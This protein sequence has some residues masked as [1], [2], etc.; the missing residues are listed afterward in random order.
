MWELVERERERSVD[1]DE[2]GTAGRKAPGA[3]RARMPRPERPAGERMDKCA[4]K[5]EAMGTR[6]VDG[7]SGGLC[8]TLSH[9]SDVGVNPRMPRD[10]I[11]LYSSAE[12]GGASEGSDLR[13]YSKECMER[14]TRGGG[15]GERGKRSA[16]CKPLS[17]TAHSEKNQ[18]AKHGDDEVDLFCNDEIFISGQKTRRIRVVVMM[19]MMVRCHH[20]RSLAAS[21]GAGG[22]LALICTSCKTP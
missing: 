2:L 4:E 21:R 22:M 19:M 9:P 17:R 8:L 16:L 10:S 13:L 7:G 18:A 14:N 6:W 12:P 1:G 15:G 5:K 11:S 20:H 3:M